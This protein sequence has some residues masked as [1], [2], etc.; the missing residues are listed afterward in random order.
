M[1]VRNGKEQSEWIARGYTDT[2]V[3]VGLTL[4][5]ER[6]PGGELV[7]FQCFEAGIVHPFH[8]F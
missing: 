3:A 4:T 1:S 2:R 8:T 6:T 7:V 5:H